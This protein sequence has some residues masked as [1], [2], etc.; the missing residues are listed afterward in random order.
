MLVCSDLISTLYFVVKLGSH[1]IPHS[2]KTELGV[3]LNQSL[4]HIMVQT[5]DAWKDLPLP[6]AW[7]IRYSG[8]CF[9][10]SFLSSFNHEDYYCFLK[11]I[12]SG[13]SDCIPQNMLC[14]IL[15]KI[16]IR[17]CNLDGYCTSPFLSNV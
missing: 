15:R 13:C 9:C 6:D 10:R 7:Y 16:C 1:M 8:I 2:L 14:W 17:V 11:R 3:R 4:D 5:L 12:T